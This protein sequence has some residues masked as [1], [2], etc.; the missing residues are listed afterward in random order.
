[1]ADVT[2]IQTLRALDWLT[3]LYNLEVEFYGKRDWLLSDIE[4]LREELA[5]I[6]IKP[7]DDYSFEERHALVRVSSKTLYWLG[8]FAV[9][10]VFN[11]W[12]SVDFKSE[13]N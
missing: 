6:P 10:M 2:R 9:D 12:A 13:R 5:K 8:M 1:M 3:R 4:N 11:K 7:R